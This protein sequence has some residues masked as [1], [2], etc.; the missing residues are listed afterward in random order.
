MDANIAR[1]IDMKKCVA[2]LGELVGKRAHKDA[3]SSP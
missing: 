2:M 1:P 3:S